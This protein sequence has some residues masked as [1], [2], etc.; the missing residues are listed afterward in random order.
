G[1]GLLSTFPR[2]R[3]S[4]EGRAITSGAG[5][6]PAASQHGR[7]GCAPAGTR[8]SPAAGRRPQ[9]PAPP[10]APRCPEPSRAGCRGEPVSRT[11]RSRGPITADAALLGGQ[12]LLVVPV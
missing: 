3:L 6:R 10:A 9:L 12:P 8:L 4:S 2:W 5:V 1:G 7:P 11:Q